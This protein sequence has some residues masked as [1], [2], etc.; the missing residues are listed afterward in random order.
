M[1]PANRTYAGR[2]ADERAESRRAA[3]LAA[4]RDLWGRHGLA[5]LSVRGVCAEAKLVDRYFYAEFGSVEA[6][7]VAIAQDVGS[8]L[9]A[10]MLDAGARGETPIDRLRLGLQGYLEHIIGDPAILRVFAGAGSVQG[11]LH[12]VRQEAQRQV[13]TAIALSLDPSRPVDE[14]DQSFV[15]AYF[16]VGGVTLLIERWL[17]GSS[18]Q[19]AAQLATDAVELCRRTL[20]LT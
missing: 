2:G 15:A 6:L 16:C 14:R 10:A 4:G 8:E 17:A 12:A 20:R 5:G 19:T 3:F 1:A 9:H 13:A 7:S 18:R 11:P